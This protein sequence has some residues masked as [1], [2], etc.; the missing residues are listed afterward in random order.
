[1][2]INTYT[3]VFI[4]ILLYRNSSVTEILKI[5]TNENLKKL[6]GTYRGAIAP[7]ATS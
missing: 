5:K 3:I 4:I 6:Q 1:M 2:H 7:F